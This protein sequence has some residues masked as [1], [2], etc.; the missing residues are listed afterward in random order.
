MASRSIP[1]DLRPRL[2][3]LD[4]PIL[5]RVGTADL[6]TPPAL[7]E[8]I[9]EHAAR[10]HLELVEGVGHALIHED[11]EG[12]VASTRRALDDALARRDAD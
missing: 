4:V 8:E 11:L 10:G 5:A 7:S 2:A 3:E 6:A 12:T 1:E 9:V